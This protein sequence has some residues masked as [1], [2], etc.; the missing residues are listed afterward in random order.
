MVTDSVSKPA[1]SVVESGSHRNSAFYLVGA[2]LQGLGIVFVQPFA[3][4]I[5]DS[6]REWGELIISVSVIQVGV[7]L[8]AAGLPLAITR[9]WFDDKDG[10]L[11]AR[12]ISGFLGIAG[13]ALGL[14]TALGFWLYQSVI[15][16]SGQATFT[17]ALVTMGVLASVLAAQAILRAQERPVAFVGLSIGASVG[18]HVTGLLAIWLIEPVAWLYLAGFALA[19]VVTACLSLLIAPPASPSATP[20]AVREALAIG[21][22]VLPHTGA[23]MLLTQGAVFLLAFL[24]GTATSGDYGKVQVFILGTITLL[25]ALNNVWVPRIMSASK[26]ERPRR[27]HQTMST[28]SLA[29]L[30]IVVLASGSANVMTHILADGREDLIPVAQIMPLTALGYVLYLNATTL[31]FSDR[32]TGIL[33]IVTP[34][35]LLIGIALAVVPALNGNLVAVA[36][37]N[38]AAFLVLGLVYFF[39]VR[40]RAHGGWP[41]RLYVLCSVTAIAYVVVLVFLPTDFLTGVFT[42]AAVA[43]FSGIA[44]A[45]LWRRGSMRV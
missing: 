11:R 44:G 16:G 21:L 45:V 36:L 31:L 43:L 10:P 40:K 27:M 18:A 35:V 29:A 24:S 42:C 38:A 7:V 17:I 37:A 5:M 41:V 25:G 14:A 1:G 3:V 39:L 8:A 6:D 22:P 32:R 4:R 13:L 26:E 33:A 28:A 2:L 34:A 20:G 12:A 15:A 23:L 19:V 9:A 30:G